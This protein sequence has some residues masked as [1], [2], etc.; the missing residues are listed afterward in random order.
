MINIERYFFSILQLYL[1]WLEK[2]KNIKRYY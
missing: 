2:W 1:K